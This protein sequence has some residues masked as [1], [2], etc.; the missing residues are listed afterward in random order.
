ML[1]TNAHQTAK[2]GEHDTIY[3]F[4][5]TLHLYRNYIKSIVECFLNVC[6][7]AIY[8]FTPASGTQ[9]CVCV[10]WMNDVLIVIFSHYGGFG[11]ACTVSSHLLIYFL[12]KNIIYQS[13]VT[14]APMERMIAWSFIGPPPRAHHIASTCKIKEEQAKTYDH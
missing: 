1:V 4:A 14:T 3:H 8:L 5:F 2:R 9:F 13:F 6:I 10:F 12:N 7:S 11:C